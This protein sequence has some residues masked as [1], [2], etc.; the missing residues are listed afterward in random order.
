MY[1]YVCILLYFNYVTCYACSEEVDMLGVNILVS[2][3][4]DKTAWNSLAK[5]N[6]HIKY[7]LCKVMHSGEKGQETSGQRSSALQ[8]TA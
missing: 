8:V 4:N 5:F 1:V 6:S 7:R 3:M 2:N